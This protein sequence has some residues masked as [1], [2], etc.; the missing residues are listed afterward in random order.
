MDLISVIIPIY[1]VEKYLARS[2]DSVIMQTYS[3]LEII[4]VNDGSTDGSFE[5]LCD[6]ERKDSRIKVIQQANAGLS[7]ARNR[8]INEASG[9]WIAFLDSDD[10]MDRQFIYYLHETATKHSADVAIG[11]TQY[12]YSPQKIECNNWVNNWIAACHKNVIEQSDIQHNRENIIYSCACWNKLYRRDLIESNR[13][14]FGNFR[15]EDI[16]F[17]FATALYAER[18]AIDPRAVIFYYNSNDQSIMSLSNS[19]DT[20]FDIFNVYSECDTILKKFTEQNPVK[21]AEYLKILTHFKI[22]N[23]NDWRNRT[24]NRLKSDFDQRMKDIFNKI[25]ITNNRY[26]IESSKII[27]ENYTKQ[28]PLIYIRTNKNRVK[29]LLGGFFP[30]Y[31]V[32]RKGMITTHYLFG[33]LPLLKITRV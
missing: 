24:P 19:N 11:N 25:D 6:Y 15:I 22:F 10:W 28:H 31:R 30:L 17:T 14:R 16:P 1:N 20:S 7:A 33:Y 18:I 5:I 13:L 26:I 2:L 8:G 21:G 3:N 29:Y 12:Y 23:I 9:D 27:F 4:C 32:T